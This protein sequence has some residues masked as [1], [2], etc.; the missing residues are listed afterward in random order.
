VV[1]D[2]LRSA[3]P[4]GARRSKRSKP[5]CASAR[6]ASTCIRVADDRE[7]AP[8]TR[9]PT[10]GRYS[11]DLH[12]ADCD[13]HYA[14]RRR[15]LFSF[16]SPLGACETCRGFGRV[17]GIDFGLVI[18]TPKSLARGRREA[19][20][21]ESF[22]ECQDDL[23]EAREEARRGDGHSVARPAAKHR[24]WVLEGDP[25]WKSWDKSWPGKWYGVRRFFAWLESKAYKMHIR[26]LLSKYRAYTPCETCD[27]A[28]LKPDALLWRGSATRAADT[29]LPAPKRFRPRGVTGPRRCRSLPA[30]RSTT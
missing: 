1:Q 24:Q 12:C 27:G 18:P 14:I 13:L 2:R 10:P 25:G 7:K 8:G 15:A 22:K 17:I 21:D 3:T 6:A 23:A 16:N 4:S 29:A 19:L 28:R 5:R 20:A 30:W 11:S 26:V 9:R